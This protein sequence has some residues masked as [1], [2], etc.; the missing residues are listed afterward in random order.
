M[1]SIDS[2]RPK[3]LHVEPPSSAARLTSRETTSFRLCGLRSAVVAADHRNDR[4]CRT[5]LAAVLPF[6]HVCTYVRAG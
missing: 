6:G 5:F 4:R 2:F 3:N 1:V